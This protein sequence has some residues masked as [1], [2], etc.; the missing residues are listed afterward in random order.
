MKAQTIA[1]N[2][3]RVENQ[4]KRLALMIQ[5]PPSGCRDVAVWRQ[6]QKDKLSLLRRSLGEQREMLA[7]LT[8][9]SNL[10]LA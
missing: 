10:P 2:I 7:R 9:Q 5:F 4:E 3:G 6:V 8:S 1:A